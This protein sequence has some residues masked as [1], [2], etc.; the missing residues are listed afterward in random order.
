MRLFLLAAVATVVALPALAQTWPA[1]PVRLI[2]P[3]AP[4]GSTDNATRAFA[5]KLSQ[6]LGQQFVIENKGG[7]AGAIGVEL[8]ARS[9]PDGYSFVVLP[10][11]TVTVLPHARKLPY[12]PFKDFTYVGRFVAGTLT[13]AVQPNLAAN[14][15]KSYLAL[16]KANPGKYTY[17]SPGIG[18]MPHLAVE[19]LKELASVD[20]LHVPYRGGAEAIQDFLA[21]NVHS[22]HESNTMPLAKGG[23]AKLLAVI[24]TERHP[25][26]PDVPTLA[27][28][29]PGY[30]VVNWF[31]LA[32][33][34]GVPP[35]V[36]GKLSA[37]MNAIALME[38]VRARLL[39][40][41]LRPIGD[42]PPEMAGNVRKEFDRYQAMVQR[43]N[44]KME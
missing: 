5:D 23:K 11:A 21:G 3:Y 25:E 36:V 28:Q 17:G 44:I 38:D 32:G 1:R 13:F 27:E 2:V 24:D 34:A 40:L 10:L 19:A 33:P 22:V 20:V 12:D 30:D 15:M 37:E 14:D 42:T 26:F 7:A 29:V 43:L 31:G 4:G 35:E 39:P 8:G 18:A 9:A 16:A 6:R 41:G